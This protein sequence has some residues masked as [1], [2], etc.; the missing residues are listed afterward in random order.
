[1]LDVVAVWVTLTTHAH[2]RFSDNAFLMQPG[3]RVLK[4]FPFEGFE[5]SELKSTL[6]VEHVATYM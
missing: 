3:S 1:M 5:L 4:F 2:G 6:R